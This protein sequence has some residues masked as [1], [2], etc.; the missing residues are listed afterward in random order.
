[1]LGGFVYKEAVEWGVRSGQE[2]SL[3]HKRPFCSKTASHNNIFVFCKWHR[4]SDKSVL[5]EKS[6]IELCVKVMA[7]Q[8]APRGAVRGS[9]SGWRAW[10][11]WEGDWCET[12]WVLWGHTGVMSAGTTPGLCLC[13]LLRTVLLLRGS[14]W[15]RLL[16]V[17]ASN[18]FAW[19][20]LR[21]QLQ[22]HYL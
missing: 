18:A 8:P 1:M 17:S 21:K 2:F 5:I 20:A 22:I 11:W 10:P 14:Q 9:G 6:R 16:G 4:N 19:A 7:L 3:N 15:M 12:C 13:C